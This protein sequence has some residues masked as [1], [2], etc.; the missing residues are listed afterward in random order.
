[1]KEKVLQ[2]ITEKRDRYTKHFLSLIHI[3]I[4]INREVSAVLEMTIRY[5]EKHLQKCWLPV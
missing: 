4:M 5:T 3:L 2:E 1:M